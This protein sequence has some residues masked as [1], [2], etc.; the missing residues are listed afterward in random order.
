MSI[1]Q[2]LFDVQ[3]VANF[4]KKKKRKNFC[5]LREQNVTVKGGCL[6]VY[7]WKTNFLSYFCL[8]LFQNA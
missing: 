6:E 7:I 1:L 8:R 3:I 5:G 4:K 2:S